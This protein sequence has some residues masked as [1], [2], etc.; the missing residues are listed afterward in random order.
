[1]GREKPK[2]RIWDSP[3][4]LKGTP[5]QVKKGMKK[6]HQISLTSLWMNFPPFRTAGIGLGFDGLI[7]IL[8]P[9]L[10]PHTYSN[11]NTH[12]I[13]L[14]FLFSNESRGE[15]NTAPAAT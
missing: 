11:T 7:S 9:A 1:M 5:D 15:K 4:G 10:G 2:N 14:N 13:Y 12:H 6:G 8:M 3:V